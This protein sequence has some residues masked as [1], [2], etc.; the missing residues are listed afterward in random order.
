M[1][2]LPDQREAMREVIARAAVEPHAMAVLAGDDAETVVL[3]LVQPS[4]TGWRLLRLAFPPK[5]AVSS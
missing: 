4:L 3:D 2:E 1:S 5:R